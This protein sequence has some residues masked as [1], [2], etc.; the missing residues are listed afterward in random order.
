M[1]LPN[2]IT[3][4]RLF[5]VPVAIYLLMQSAFLA[6]FLLFLL[7][8][9][10]DAL[11]GYIAK[12]FDQVTQLGAILDPIADKALLVGVYVT[13]GMQG[14]IPVWLVVFVVF[15]DAMIIGGVV[16]LFLFRLEVRMRPLVISKVNTAAQIALAAAVLAELGLGFDMTPLVLVLIYAVAATTAVSGASYIVSWTREMAG[17]EPDEP[18]PAA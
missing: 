5:T 14:N 6:A 16:L 2:C 10:S 4:G 12:R 11:D 8:G 17:L 1:N 9:I 13:L 3:L 18:P 7:A 15:R